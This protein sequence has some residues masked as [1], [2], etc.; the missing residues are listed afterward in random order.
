MASSR[1]TGDIDGNAK[2]DLSFSA[3]DINDLLK[4]LTLEDQGGGRVQAVGYDSHDPVERTLKSYAIDLSDNPSQ[5]SILDRT[6]GEKVEVSLITGG[7]A[8][9]GS[10]VGVERVEVATKDGKVTVEQ[11]NVLT[12]EGLRSARLA[13]VQRIRFLNPSLDGEL[14]KA[15]DTL[16][17][18]HDTAKKS[19]S[20][21][22]AGNGRRP[23]RVSYVVESPIW[24][25]S[26]RLAFDQKNKPLL[27][28]WAMIEN[29]TDED[30]S[31][32]KMA[33]V[34]GRPIS[35]KMDL[36]SPLYM[37]RPLVE[38]ELFASLRPPTYDGPMD[39]KR[40][41][42]E[43]YAHD[44]GLPAKMELDPSAAIS[45]PKPSGGAEG[46][47]KRPAGTSASFAERGFIDVDGSVTAD[48]T[49]TMNIGQGVTSAAAGSQLGDYFQYV[50]E[51]AISVPRQKSAML[52]I[53]NKQIEG[54]KVSIYNP[55]THAKYPLLGFKFKNLTGSSLMQGP[56]TIFDESTYAGD[57]RL[58]DVQANEERLISYAI[59]LGTEV[60][61]HYKQ[62]P[63]QYTTA[64]VVKGILHATRK[65]HEERKYAAVNR[66]QT[67]RTL[68]I[69]HPY[70]AE[71]ALVGNSPKPAERD[72]RSISLRDEIAGRTEE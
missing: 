29:P 1:R 11:L 3:G 17:T 39:R 66:S 67:E 32:V 26:Y 7:Q 9:V 54:T 19:V 45:A 16:G 49:G 48:L 13:D 14:R 71:H 51:E 37:Q 69:E 5:S 21:R 20:L 55:N 25:T 24:K 42:A 60:E 50:L 63:V 72:A 8:I 58:P 56:I 68:L 43:H 40:A 4:S 10:I 46:A 34:S 22:F 70:R 23:V 36:Y 64:K 38:P 15:L 35:F 33:L 53:V 59:D 18:G 2:V 12:G 61:S 44:I 27:Q 41:E 28:G 65:L 57:A 52:P 31:D 30:W 47:S 6:R 62:A